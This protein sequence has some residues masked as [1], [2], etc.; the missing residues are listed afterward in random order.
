MTTKM[1]HIKAYWMQGK[2]C[3]K[4]NEMEK[5]LQTHKVP[6]PIQDKVEKCKQTD[7]KQKLK[8]VI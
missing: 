8:P 4:G 1:Q 3:S 7:N 5:Y 6:R 2:Q